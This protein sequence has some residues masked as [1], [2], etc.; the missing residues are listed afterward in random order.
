MLCSFSAPHC[1]R[2]IFRGASRSCVVASLRI[3]L[4]V[5]FTITLVE[6]FLQLARDS[7]SKS[8]MPI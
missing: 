3:S 5:E 6:F 8:D 4:G 1:L 7:D 2:S